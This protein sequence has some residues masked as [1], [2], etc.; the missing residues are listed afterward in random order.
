MYTLFF[1]RQKADQFL[2]LPGY[3]GELSE[4]EK[5]SWK[6]NADIICENV[7]DISK[8]S[9]INYLLEWDYTSNIEHKAYPDDEFSTG[10][11]WQVC[12]FMK[13]LDSPIR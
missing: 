8:E 1:S 3:W 4:E 13:N 10:D 7:K 5:N 9:I 11:W 6:G 2:P 12:D